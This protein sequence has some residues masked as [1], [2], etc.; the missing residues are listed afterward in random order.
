MSTNDTPSVD[1]ALRAAAEAATPGPWR[2]GELGEVETSQGTTIVV[3]WAAYGLTGQEI[4][5]AAF[6]AAADPSTVLA[7][8]D[9][10]ERLIERV[11]VLTDALTT[12]TYAFIVPY[13]YG[14]FQCNSPECCSG[15]D[16]EFPNRRP[17]GSSPDSIDHRDGCPVPAA[18]RVLAEVKP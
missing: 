7:I 12:I 8:L 11:K 4:S 3:E 1:E 10:R 13:A 5:D 15:N 2:V 14:G 18:E 17:W 16:P 6:I 9:E